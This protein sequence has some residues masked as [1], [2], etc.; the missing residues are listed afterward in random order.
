MSLNVSRARSIAVLIA[1]LA[2]PALAELRT[3]NVFLITVDGL[4]HQELFSGV[5]PLLLENKERAGIEDLD[6]LREQYWRPT[7]TERREA[8]LPFFWGTLARQGIVIG[9]KARGSHVTL[10]NPVRISYPGYAEILTGQAQLAITSNDPI[11]MPRETLLEFARRKLNVSRTQVAAFA[12]WNVFNAITARNPDAIFTNAG[13]QPVP[14][15]IATPEMA[16][17]NALQMQMLTPWDTVRHDA[18]TAGLALAYVKTYQ[19]RLLYVAFGETD[20]WAHDRRYDRVIH[21]ARFFDDRLR[22]LWSLLQS[23]EHYRD[24]TT[25]VITTDHGRGSTLENWTSH[26]GDIDGAEDVWIA[27]IGPDTPDRGE[28]APTPTLH[29]SNVAGTV[30]KLLGLDTQEFNPQAGAPISQAFKN[31]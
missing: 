28:V 4:R 13:Y 7:A 19:P 29:T 15:D 24:R 23:T 21:A 10:T 27:V 16:V 6:R 9:N 22:D 26:R 31:P 25:L 11:R 18:I 2:T 17:L 14:P 20:D 1:M 12:S 3:H 8:L 30:L 5:D